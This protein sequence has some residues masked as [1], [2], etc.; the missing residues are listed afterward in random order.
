MCGVC[1]AGDGGEVPALARKRAAVGQQNSSRL[2]LPPRLHL[3]L[4]FSSHISFSLPGGKKKKS[5]CR[6]RVLILE[7]EHFSC[8]NNFV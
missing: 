1:L 2:H 3:F 7:L 8:S 6:R 5:T 4:K